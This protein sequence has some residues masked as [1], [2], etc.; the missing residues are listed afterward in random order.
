[1]DAPWGPVVNWRP[2]LNSDSADIADASLRLPAGN[3]TLTVAGGGFN[4]TGGYKFRLLDFAQATGFTPGTAVTATLSPSYATVLYSFSGQAGDRVYFDGQPATGFTYAPSARLYAPLG[5]LILSRQV[6]TDEDTFTLPQTGVYT[7]AVEGR[8][9]DAHASANY[10]FN[11][12]PQNYPTNTVTLGSTVSG[13]LPVPGQRNVHEFSLPTSTMLCFDVLTNANLQWRLDAPWGPV[14]NWRPFLNS[15]SAD[16]ADA[17][18]RLPAGNYTLTVAG[19]GFNTTG[20]YQFRL[21]D[22]AQATGFTPGTPVAATLSPS[23]GTVLYSFS[24]QAG[25]RVYFDGQPATGFTYVPS[26]RLYAPLGNL[27]MS[28]QVDTDE[29]TFTLPQTG[30]YT[31][32]VEGRIYDAHASANY[33]FN[34]VPNPPIPPQP[35]FGTNNATSV[36]LYGVVAENGVFKFSF[37]SAANFL[38][39]VQF[40]GSLLAPINWQPLTN[41]TGDG[42][43]FTV[44]DKVNPTG[45]RFYRIQVQ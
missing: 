36:T 26:A 11:L 20:G 44:T 33:A 12:V 8:I 13:S 18:L 21:L 23:Y 14:V 24:G 22:F 7:L 35:L 42:S 19:G 40:T 15:D 29:D 25:D 32:A 2:F 41:Y 37:T 17:S 3:Y 9:Y 1:L 45:A 10:A 16:I 38:Y 39:T 31:L 34:L 4:T 5:N 43:V 30:V 6:D 28:R 27:I